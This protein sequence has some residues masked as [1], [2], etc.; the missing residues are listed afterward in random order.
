MWSGEEGEL[1]SVPC[2]SLALALV[3]VDVGLVAWGAAIAL[4]LRAMCG[5]VHV[6]SPEMSGSL[7]G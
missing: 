1:D 2:W 3:D 7:K 4:A 6:V 5:P